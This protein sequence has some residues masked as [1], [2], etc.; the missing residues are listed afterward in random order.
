MEGL[1]LNSDNIQVL[2]PASYCELSM[3]RHLYPILI[4]QP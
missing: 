2:N 3:D 4:D 1:L